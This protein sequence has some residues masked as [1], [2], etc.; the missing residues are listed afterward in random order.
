MGYHK[1]IKDSFSGL[2]INFDIYSRTS[3][4]VHEVNASAF[5]RKLYEDGKFIEKES[6]QYYDQEAKTFLADRYITGTCPRCGAEGAYGDQCEK[7]GA[8]LSPDELINPER[9]SAGKESDKTLVSASGP[10]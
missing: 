8:T 6:E 1:V 3:S 10:V 7:C 2:G 5:F 9:K 4:K